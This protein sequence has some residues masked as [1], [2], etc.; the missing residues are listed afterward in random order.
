MKLKNIY[1]VIEAFM[2]WLV[3]KYYKF[4]FLYSYEIQIKKI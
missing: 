2:V 4:I 1:L 3:N